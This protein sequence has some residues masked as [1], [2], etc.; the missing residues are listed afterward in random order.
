[1]IKEYKFYAANIADAVD[2]VSEMTEIIDE[3]KSEHLD[4]EGKVELEDIKE[5]DMPIL[6]TLKILK[7]DDKSE[8]QK[9]ED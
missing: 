9:L 2:A 8:A 5:G 1:M 3:W 4:Y 6:V 7:K